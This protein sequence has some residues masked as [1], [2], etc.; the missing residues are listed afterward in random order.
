M[1]KYK[2]AIIGSTGRG[3]YGHGLD[4]I[5]QHMEQCDVVAVADQDDVGRQKAVAR[6]GAA[7]GYA[8]Y[9]DMLAKE[10]PQI[11]AVCPRWIDQHRDMVLACA[12]HGCHMYMEKPFCRTLGEADEMI[13]ACE[14]RHLK[15]AVAHISRYSPQLD[16]IRKLIQ[17][18]EIG[19]VLEIRARG[20]EDARGGSEDLWVL[21][22]HVLDLMRAFA[23]EPESCYAN[24]Y[25]QGQ[26]VTRDHIKAGNEGVGPLAGDRVDAMYR[27]KSGITGYFSSQKAAGGSPNRFGLRILGSKG[28]IDHTSGFA[29]PAFLLNDATWGLSSNG[30]KWRAISSAGIDQPET[31]TAQG[32]EGG[33]PAAAYDLI[34]A[35]EEDRQPKCSMYEARGTIEMVLA[36]FESH[37]AGGP[38]PMPL[39]TKV[40]PLG[41][42]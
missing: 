10:K 25:Q 19:D 6:T 24:L 21:G 4:A 42:L 40:N 33:N 12:E 36:V 16:V 17:A 18:G 14:M 32:Y 5:W 35:I 41:L 1:A 20:K 39:E 34:A 27:F 38:V 37:R 29:N 31:I 9:R 8:D 30:T 22:T 28:M 7:R 15:L 3:D 13:Q 2:V 23:G 11:V 26:R